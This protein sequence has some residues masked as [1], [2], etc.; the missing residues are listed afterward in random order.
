M[1]QVEIKNSTLHFMTCN[2]EVLVDDRQLTF[3]TI[4]IDIF[5]AK[6]QYNYCSSIA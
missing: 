3:E 2:M 4:Y 1:G 6:R 5:I